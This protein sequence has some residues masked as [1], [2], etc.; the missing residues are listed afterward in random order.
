[1]VPENDH[2]SEEHHRVDPENDKELRPMLMSPS[3]SLKINLVQSASQDSHSHMGGA[4]ERMIGI[5]RRILDSMLCD[6]KNLTQDVIVT[7]MAEVCAIMNPRPLVPISND[8]DISEVLSPS[9]ILTLKTGTDEQPLGEVDV[10]DMLRSQWKRVKHLSDAFWCR[11]RKEYLQTLQPRRK[12]N[13]EE[14][15]IR[16]G[17]IV[18]LRDKS[19]SRIYW[20]IARVNKVFPS[21][22]QKVRK[23]KVLAFKD[24]K[25][26]SYVR[27]IVE[28]VLLVNSE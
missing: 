16:V 24:S 15:N 22:D 27:P 6:V 4:W 28:L 19:V 17:D 2:D 5:V 25:L 13:H 3:P 20:P 1:M 18:L 8:A 7:L 12:W 21:P 10:K 23:V 11:W 9:T 14:D 26:V